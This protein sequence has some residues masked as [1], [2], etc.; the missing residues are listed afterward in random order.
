M[1]LDGRKTK[2][3]R[4]GPELDLT[5]RFQ[6]CAIYQGRGIDTASAPRLFVISHPLGLCGW[7]RKGGRAEVAQAQG[8]RQHGVQAQAARRGQWVSCSAR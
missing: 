2:R 3:P 1:R 7:V 8:G 6:G 4:Q 5:L